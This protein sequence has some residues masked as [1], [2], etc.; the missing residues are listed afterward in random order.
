MYLRSYATRN[1]SPGINKE[2]FSSPTEEMY[3]DSFGQY[4]E[5][6]ENLL[7]RTAGNSPFY[8]PGR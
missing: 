7:I 3:F 2:G 8:E 1:D 5:L 4:D 6:G